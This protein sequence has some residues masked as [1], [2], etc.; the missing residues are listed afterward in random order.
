MD[1]DRLYQLLQ[2]ETRAPGARIF[3]G[4]HHAMVAAGIGIMLADTVG[5]WR[6]A[7]RGVLDAGFQIV[8]AFFFAEYLLR[9]IAAPGAPGAEARG[10]WPSRLAWAT[11]LGGIFDFLGA[12]PG[13]L[14]VVF[15]PGY[16]S[17]FAFIWAFKLVRY[18]P[19]LASLERV[20][21]NARQALLSVLLGFG[22]LLLLAA[23]RSRM[24]KPSRTDSNACRALLMT[25]S[26]LANPGE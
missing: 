15:N 16:A 13:V 17:L 1:E 24:P 6:E 20:M 19:G 8:C 9:L 3:R 22:I 10:K 25:R 7:Y 23:S 18:C 4:V 11:S 2:P 5:E 14:D 26:R 21:T 12:L